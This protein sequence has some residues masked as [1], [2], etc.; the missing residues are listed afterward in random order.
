M[1]RPNLIIA[2]LI[3]SLSII[4]TPAR[5]SGWTAQATILDLPG[6]PFV[7]LAPDG[8]QFVHRA[9]NS[10]C[11]Y[12]LSGEE[13]SCKSLVEQK[14]GAYDSDSVRWS[15]DSTKV[16]FSENYF[17]VFQDS[18]IW[19]LDTTTNTFTDITPAPNR[20]VIMGQNENPDLIFTVDMFPEWSADSQSIYFVRY[21]LQNGT[22]TRAQVFRTMLVGGDAEKIGSVIAESPLM[23]WGIALA[24]DQSYFVYDLVDYSP[25]PDGKVGTW[26]ID[27]GSGASKFAVPPMPQTVPFKYQFSPDGSQILSIGFAS[28]GEVSDKGRTLETNPFYI[29]PIAGGD[30]HH[31]SV[32]HY[33]NS[34]GWGLEGKT[35]VYSTRNSLE[36]Q[37]ASDGLYITDMSGE[38]GEMV[39]PGIFSAPT[40]SERVPLVWAANNTLLLKQRV[41]G[42]IKLV[43]VQ[44]K[45]A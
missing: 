1:R 4:M 9:R 32:D 24:P 41:N 43:L 26:T 37:S 10:L 25:K 12:S 19:V 29:L 7:S 38:N 16:A 22:K 6:A 44:L 14:I 34:A 42:E 15:P 28:I 21:V 40:Q 30:L 39:L 17:T 23:T 36:S 33:V 3:F 2:V 11:L 27:V 5:A 45:Q 13:Q 20:D 35:L 18:D 8:S 31:L